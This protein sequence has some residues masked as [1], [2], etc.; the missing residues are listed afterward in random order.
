MCPPLGL[1]VPSRDATA[2]E[3]RIWL[4]SDRLGCGVLQP[5]SGN[6][7]GLLGSERIKTSKRLLRDARRR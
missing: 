1:C 6:R 7:L 2:R 5:N 4:P 3:M